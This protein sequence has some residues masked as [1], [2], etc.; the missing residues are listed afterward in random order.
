MKLS[1]RIEL[2]KCEAL[3]AI[4]TVDGGIAHGRKLRDTAKQLLQETQS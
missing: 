4:P 2:A 1:I 3:C